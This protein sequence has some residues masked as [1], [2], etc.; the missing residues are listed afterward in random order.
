M[1]LTVKKQQGTTLLVPV[2]LLLTLVT[3]AVVSYSKQLRHH[4]VSLQRDAQR[5]ELHF[6]SQASL[7]RTHQALGSTTRWQTA[8]TPSQR[9]I[10]SE[11]QKIDI[12]GATITL[13]S[14]SA[15]S[16]D[17]LT[18]MSDIQS[19]SIVRSP[20]IRA[21]PTHAAI[22]AAGMNPTAEMTLTGLPLTRS[23]LWTRDA[24]APSEAI[25]QHCVSSA[26]TTC[27]PLTPSYS[28]FPDDIF[29]YLFGIPRSVFYAETLPG[30]DTLTDCG[31][32]A[33]VHTRIIWISGNCHVPVGVQLGSDDNP[34]L[35][36]VEDGHLSLASGVTVTGMLV[37]L[38]RRSELPKDI[39]Q[40]S[41]SEIIGAAVVAQNL[42]ARSILRVTY[43][44]TTLTT[45]QNAAYTQRASFLSGSWHDF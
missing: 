1:C 24:P 4:T 19:M 35:L 37:T 41:T 40:H 36:I 7:A 29:T 43:S 16:A 2:C 13:F 21:Y 17:E 27:Q 18:A 30:S 15:T 9:S 10:I 5:S 44:K 12:R 6:T 3:A 39:I 42:S 11:H 28:A 32:I 22:I 23:A 34:V 14:L 25:Q 45:L 33:S 31:S 26:M 8:L 20:V 38:S